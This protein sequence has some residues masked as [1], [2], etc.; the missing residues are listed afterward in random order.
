MLCMPAWI[1]KYP[2]AG[3]GVRSL[4]AGLGHGGRSGG[5][6][7]AGVARVGGSSSGGDMSFPPSY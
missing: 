5:P 1:W 3:R 6:W 2:S 4:H 7:R